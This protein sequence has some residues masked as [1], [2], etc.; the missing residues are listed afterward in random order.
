MS[1]LAARRLLAQM[2]DDELAEMILHLG[3][4]TLRE[5]NRLRWRT[6]D[7]V[8]LPG[9][10]TVDSIVSLAFEK[11]LTG[12]RNWD[13]EKDPDLKKYL[14]NVIDSLLSHLATSKD[15][16]IL[17]FVS[18]GKCGDDENKPLNAE[19]QPVER[20]ADWLARP[21]LSP[22]LQLIKKEEEQRNE[23]AIELLLAE[24]GDDPTLIRIIQ[25]M[26]EGHDKA[27]KIAEVT[28]ISVKETYNSMKRLDRKTAKIMKQIKAANI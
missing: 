28:G 15:N 26:L 5:S 11:V 23:R 18:V 9:G 6:G 12:E 8:E 7:S 21:V 22:E 24:S 25:A 1:E 16:T 14:M 2:Q 20:S 3:R 19:P 4:Y 27:G 13:P 10:E 17:T